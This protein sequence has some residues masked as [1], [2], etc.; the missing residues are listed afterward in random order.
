M[1][2]PGKVGG[3]ERPGRSVDARA[4]ARGSC[5][6]GQECADDDRAG[7]GSAGAEEDR[8]SARVAATGPESVDVRDRLRCRAILLLEV[9]RAERVDEVVGDVRTFRVAATP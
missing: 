3:V 2:R 7:A 1:R 4:R 9:A 8:R 5:E 6:D